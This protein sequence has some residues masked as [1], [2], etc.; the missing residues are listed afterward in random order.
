M[1]NKEEINTEISIRRIVYP[2]ETMVKAFPNKEKVLPKHIKNSG[3]NKC[4]VEKDTT[5]Q[6]TIKNMI[7]RMT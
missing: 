2:K 4:S 5:S 7:P 1:A 3:K 6:R